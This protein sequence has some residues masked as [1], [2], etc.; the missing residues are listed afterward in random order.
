MKKP[1]TRG[2]SQERRGRVPQ[3]KSHSDMKIKLPP[4]RYPITELNLQSIKH[5]S[6][7]LPENG[8]APSSSLDIATTADTSKR[9]KQVVVSNGRA[10]SNGE[11]HSVTFTASP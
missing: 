3:P 7:K 9:S 4:I 1:P 6:F 11:F 8:V 5:V 10:G 2:I